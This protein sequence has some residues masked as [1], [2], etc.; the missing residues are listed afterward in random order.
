MQSSC[1]CLTSSSQCPPAQAEITTWPSH[2]PHSP[3]HKAVRV[4]SF[5]VR[6]LNSTLR[7]FNQNQ[8]QIYPLHPNT[9]IS[10]Y[11][12]QHDPKSTKVNCRTFMNK[13]L[14]FKFSL[15]SKVCN[16]LVL[17]TLIH[18]SSKC[19]AC[20]AFRAGAYRS[21]DKCLQ[22][23]M[24]GFLIRVS[25]LRAGQPSLHFHWIVV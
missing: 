13:D 16:E 10:G 8:L 9:Y 20:V 22:R 3:S 1:S 21:V 17:P 25:A 11:V 6:Q 4:N 5:Q 12:Q 23:L 14:G 2:S 24:L 19:V 18:S 15:L 7:F